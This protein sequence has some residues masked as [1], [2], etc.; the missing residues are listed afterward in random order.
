MALREYPF[1]NLVEA[2]ESQFTARKKL[3]GGV[4]PMAERKAEAESQQLE[5]EARQRDAASSLENIARKWWEWWSAGK[6]PRHADYVLRRLEAE[7]FPR[8]RSQ[9]YR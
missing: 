8:V 7:V 5:A 6:S 3:V 1:V 2:R 4:D 9:I